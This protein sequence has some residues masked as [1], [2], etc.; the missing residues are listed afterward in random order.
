MKPIELV[1]LDHSQDDHD[2]DGPESLTA[3]AKRLRHQD[4]RAGGGMHLQS[5]TPAGLL[6]WLAASMA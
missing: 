6:K 5:D 3:M 1:Y 4:P 2:E